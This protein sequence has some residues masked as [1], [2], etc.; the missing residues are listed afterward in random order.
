[1]ILLEFSSSVVCAVLCCA[2]C[3]YDKARLEIRDV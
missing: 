3:H 2:S 1:M